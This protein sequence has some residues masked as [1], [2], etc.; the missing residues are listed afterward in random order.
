MDTIGAKSGSGRDLG[1]NQPHSAHFSGS[2]G[3]G[4]VVG[5]T[6]TATS[7]DCHSHPS[8]RRLKACDTTRGNSPCK[9]V[10][11]RNSRTAQPNTVSARA[12]DPPGVDQVEQPRFV[13]RRSPNKYFPA[14]LASTPT[15]TWGTLSE[16]SSSQRILPIVR[17]FARKPPRW[18]NACRIGRPTRRSR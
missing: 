7:T 10:S 18:T 8:S 6:S 3:S 5:G 16:I 12:T 1:S 2:R 17:I 13:P 11:S 14:R 9:P 15:P 4:S